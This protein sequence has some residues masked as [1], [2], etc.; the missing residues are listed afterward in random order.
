MKLELWSKHRPKSTKK[1]R[2]NHD[3]FSS[4]RSITLREEDLA[5][6][7]ALRVIFLCPEYYSSRWG[8]FRDI[9]LC[10]SFKTCSNNRTTE[11]TNPRASSNLLTN[12]FRP[13]LMYESRAVIK[14]PNKYH[15]KGG[16]RDMMHFPLSGVLLFEFRMV[17]DHHPALRV[18]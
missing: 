3:V 4:V 16:G 8:Y 12:Y 7:P 10:E 13:N 18:T 15:K 6:D 2:P 17:F 9:L 14:T 11:G 1:R 5:M